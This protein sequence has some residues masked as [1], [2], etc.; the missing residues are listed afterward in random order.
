MRG[1]N[2]IFDRTYHLYEA[3][4]ATQLHQ[5]GPRS[6]LSCWQKAPHESVR[7]CG[8][9]LQEITAFLLVNASDQIVESKHVFF[10]PMGCNQFLCYEPLLESESLPSMDWPMRHGSQ[11][12]Q[13]ALQVLKKWQ[14][15]TWFS[16][17]DW[18][19]WK[20]LEAQGKLLPY[21]QVRF[22][23]HFSKNRKKACTGRVLPPHNVLKNLPDV[24]RKLYQNTRWAESSMIE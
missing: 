6:D 20:I 2:R 12:R 14:V 7:A 8:R 10:L 11:I 3:L 15:Q 19:T 13:V 4:D 9:P 16:S 5:V 21:I 23:D 22:R 17:T 1:K 18:S 24:K